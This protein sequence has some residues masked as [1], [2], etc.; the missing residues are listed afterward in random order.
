[1]PWGCAALY[2]LRKEERN[3]F[4]EKTAVGI[5][6]DYADHHP[7]YAYGI[8]NPRTRR[9]L[10]RQ[11]VIFLIDIFPMRKARETTGFSRDGEM[12]VAYRAER[13]PA[14]IR[15]GA[16]VETSYGDWAGPTLPKFSDHTDCQLTDL[17]DKGDDFPPVRSIPRNVPGHRPFPPGFGERS[18]VE[19][20]PPTSFPPARAESRGTTPP[21]SL[22]LAPRHAPAPPAAPLRTRTQPRLLGG[23]AR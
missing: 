7:L 11:D 1:M 8:W 4:E 18:T 14:S 16:D 22:L 19:V 5:F 15:R 3:K 20:P 13:A 17:E 2:L 21:A 23:T 9:I 6:V 12:V 10:Y